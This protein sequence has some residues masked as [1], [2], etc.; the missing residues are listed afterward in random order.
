MAVATSA[1]LGQ[2]LAFLLDPLL[3][4]I[5][6]VMA[7]WLRQRPFQTRFYATST[8]GVILVIV[9]E[10]FLT[11]TGVNSGLSW[12]SIIAPMI[13]ASITCVFFKPEKVIAQHESEST[14]Q[15]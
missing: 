4:G 7:R 10:V 12:P 6:I 5:A 3:W 13:I 11:S 1:F 8:V 14:T 2:L 15:D 9:G